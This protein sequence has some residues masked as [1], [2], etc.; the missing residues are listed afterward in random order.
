[1]QESGYAFSSLA[2]LVCKKKITN[3]NCETKRKQVLKKI[4]LKVTQNLLNALK[5]QGFS[6]VESSTRFSCHKTNMY[7]IKNKYF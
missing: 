5:G 6:A 4:R 2:I 3:F 1:M 7:Q